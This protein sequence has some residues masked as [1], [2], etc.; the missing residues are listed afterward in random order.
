[1]A[2]GH[3]VAASETIGNASTYNAGVAID[4]VCHQNYVA[5]I[6]KTVSFID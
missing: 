3:A 5:I 4:M 2:T 6:R 1:M